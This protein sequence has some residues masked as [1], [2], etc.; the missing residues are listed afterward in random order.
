MAAERIIGIDFGTS[1]SVVRVKR[2]QDGVPFGS[3]RLTTESVIFNG[4]YPT[5]P[6][7]IQRVGET[8]YY[9]Y[10]AQVAKKNAVLYQGFKVDLESKDAA[11]R[12]EARG[13]T[14]EFLNYLAGVY[15]AQ[16]E[17]GHLGDVDDVERT[18][19][20]YPVKWSQ[21]T[22]SFMVEAAKRAGF[23]NVEGMDEAQAAIHAV[24]LQSEDYLKKQGYLKQGI[25]C[26]ILLLDMGA[27][28]TDL[29]LCRY[30]P[31]D[32][33]RTDILAT[34]PRQGDI[35]FGGREVEGILQDYIRGRLPEDM[36][37]MVLKKCGTDK[38]KAWKEKVVSP[39]LS[40]GETVDG[41][42]D[43]DMIAD[44]LDIGMEDYNLTRQTFE[45]S[46]KEYLARFPELVRGCIQA[47]GI[48]KEEV[49]LILLTGG[50]SQWYFVKELL[51]GEKPEICEALLPQIQ[52]NKGRV[53]PVSR[54]QETVALGLVYLP[55]SAKFTQAE[56]PM[57][58][59]EPNKAKNLTIEKKEKLAELK[60]DRKRILAQ[61]LKKCVAILPIGGKR[62][63]QIAAIDADGIRTVSLLHS[64]NG[65]KEV[66]D[67]KI[68][69]WEQAILFGSL[70][71][72][73]VRRAAKEAG[74]YKKVFEGSCFVIK[75]QE[76]WSDVIAITGDIRFFHS[77]NFFVRYFP[78]YFPPFGL[79]K[80]GT[81]ITME[82]FNSN[83]DGKQL[84]MNLQLIDILST[85]KDVVS[86]Q[87]T[88]DWLIG[89][90]KMGAY[91]IRRLDSGIGS[92]HIQQAVSVEC[93]GPFAYVVKKD[94][95]VE[96]IADY[97]AKKELLSEVKKWRDI[98]AVRCTSHDTAIVGLCRNGTVVAAGDISEQDRQKIGKWKNVVSIDVSGDD[99]MGLT[100]DGTVVA[101]G[102]LNA[103]TMR[104]RSIAAIT[105][106]YQSHALND[107]KCVLGIKENGQIIYSAIF[108]NESI[109]S[110]FSK[111]RK[112]PVKILDR[113]LENTKWQTIEEEDGPDP[114]GEGKDLSN[115]DW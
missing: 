102:D 22:K 69:I 41:F 107:E 70:D 78:P 103:L 3:D 39:A 14:Q 99:I 73:L 63:F 10:D 35:L 38:F 64:K 90:K 24:T 44:L 93:D 60:E 20:S 100:V 109:V 4:T 53:I 89:W 67:S 98:V 19:I 56:K 58:K 36:A 5:V 71:Y 68:G 74:N 30:T 94:E 104:W 34:W 54:P 12:E 79:K 75:G 43:L 52:K 2:Y 31:G 87:C 17:G 11:R 105:S 49:E 96:I 95:T 110:A 113:I 86:I 6:T 72:E 45:E 88:G 108:S 106:Y 85:W 50:H 7:L 18:I 37:D 33:P 48:C 55:I 29:V 51:A 101:T 25:P 16:S 28:T 32:Q 13:L 47:A 76:K 111:K 114:F 1:T 91:L 81:V 15:K 80:D 65:V 40:R 26:T 42:A 9:G 23:A 21:E 84:S 97:D 112:P 92:W 83:N 59:E 77:D 57:N 82:L 46:A 115:E 62:G 8:T 66:M 61:E 27:G